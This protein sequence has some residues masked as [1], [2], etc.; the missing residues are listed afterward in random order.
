MQIR[1]EEEMSMKTMKRGYEGMGI[2]GAWAP[3]G[4]RWAPI[5]LMGLGLGLGLQGCMREAPLESQ[6]QNTLAVAARG[7]TE[8]VS[9]IWNLSDLR[10][11]TVTG[12]YRL[13]A[14]ITMNSW[15][16]AFVPIG[17]IFNPFRGTF[18]GNTFTI[19]G[20]RI[21]GPAGYYQGLFSSTNGAILSKVQ[22]ANV[23]ITA[24]SISGAIVGYMINT[25]LTDSYVTGTISGSTNSN[26]Y[27]Y[28][29]GLAIGTATD[30]S[31]IYRCYATGTVKGV[32]YTAGGFF[33]EIRGAGQVNGTD[34]PR[35]KV[36]EIFTNVNVI[37]TKPGI[38][39][40]LQA[41]GLVGYAQGTM[42]Q[43]IN[44]AGPVTGFGP[45]GGVIGE[46]VNDDPSSA[47]SRFTQAVSLGKVTSN[48]VPDRAGVI[49][50][51]SGSREG[52]TRCGSSYNI[53]N[54]AGTPIS[55]GDVDCNVGRT[56]TEL[57]AAHG[58]PN[59]DLRPYTIGAFVDAQFRIDHPGT[60]SCKLGSGS[61]GDWGFGTCGVL[62]IIWRTNAN[63]QYS[64]LYRIPNP[65]IQPL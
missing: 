38:A 52:G 65:S 11:M 12:N 13:R 31:E 9:D 16:A 58:D 24:G 45:V 15:D 23:N 4:L 48:T 27:G 17:S 46:L 22:L 8:G 44:C 28:A 26:D 51:M 25:Q 49:G 1:V 5:A 63:N 42:I 55:L 50:Y 59:K 7:S 29:L 21:N 14:N 62:P 40:E 61:D 64:A 54:D 3:I 57:R 35:V 19:T 33:G 32:A 53:S 39:S 10:R 47:Q 60:N 56:S 34:D 36:Q 6:E 30:Y 41:G 2:S 20:L 37:P 18:N 43:D